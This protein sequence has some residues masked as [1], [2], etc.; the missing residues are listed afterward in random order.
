[1]ITQY[2]VW[3]ASELKTG[4]VAVSGS[5]VGPL[6]DIGQVGVAATPEGSVKVVV[7]GTGVIDPNLV[8]P[9]RQGMLVRMLAGRATSLQ[10]ATLDFQG[11]SQ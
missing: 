6:L 10:G 9:H 1:M 11:Q 2:T 3:T 5:A 4:E 7:V 8:P